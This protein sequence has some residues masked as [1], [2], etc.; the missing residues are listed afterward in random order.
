MKRRTKNIRTNI[1]VSQ[2]I[3]TILM[4]VIATSSISVMYYQVASAP[5]PVPAP[6]VEISG[7]IEN[8]KV[9]VTHSGGEPLD[10]DTELSLNIG[11][12]YLSV[13]VRDFLD[14]KSKEDGVWGLSEEFIYPLSYDFDPS[15]YPNIDIN[16]FD[17]K[18]NSLLMTGTTQVNPIC[19][20]S[21]TLNV[22]NH[23]PVELHDINFTIT[24]TNTDNIN[25]TGALIE[26]LLPH[27]LIY[28]SS[29]LDQ[30]VYDSKSGIWDIGP[31]QSGQSIT[32]NV[33]ATVADLIYDMPT[34][35]V[36]LL[37]GSESISPGNWTTM[38]K[39][40]SEAV[41]DNDIFPHNECIELTVIQFGG[42]T[43]AYAQLE[44]KPT[45]IEENNFQKIVDSILEIIQIGEKTPTSCSVYM[46]A[47]VLLNADMFA[48]STKQVVLLVTDGNP[49]H[50]CADDGDYADNS[51]KTDGPKESV[52]VAREYFVDLLNLNEYDD[53]FNALS[54]EL[55]GTGHTYDL[56]DRV[57]WPQPGYE[58]IDFSERYTPHRGWVR[59]VKSWEDFAYAIED[60]FSIIFKDFIVNTNI[61]YTDY[62]DPK[63]VN[64]LSHV[65]IQ[66]IPE[67]ASV[68]DDD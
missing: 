32:L 19:D 65:L 4:L 21:L 31:L 23:K 7:T 9:I 33:R 15:D 3:G 39:G 67:I 56:R 42:K 58:T 57:V 24:I 12:E 50:S 36:V 40:L 10:L 20:L 46:A 14:S 30:G 66:P 60:A 68:I 47:D 43:P 27:G 41:K 26:F 51:D 45:V 64:D 5:I 34:Q 55:S 44:I 63:E 61:H 18:S 1:A 28:V 38:L 37:D 29:S 62:S 11:G 49:T 54:I 22:D 35:L 17:R 13:R 52:V 59:N 25:S 8:N 48:P 53:E 16:V 6:I 2:I